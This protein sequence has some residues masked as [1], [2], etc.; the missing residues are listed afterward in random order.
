MA[1]VGHD[2]NP[3]AVQAKS[4]RSSISGNVQ[5]DEPSSRSPSKPAAHK[6]DHSTSTTHNKKSGKAR[7]TFPASRQA[8]TSSG[9]SVG[10][11]I[12]GYPKDVHSSDCSSRPG[13]AGYVRPAGLQ[14]DL[15]TDR[16]VPVGQL[17]TTVACEQY[18]LSGVSCTAS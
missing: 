9:A 2:P 14:P 4:Q 11:M 7:E 6:T 1:D 8:S 17:H 3:Q 5:P 12:P 10:E 15:P 16:S 18:I 13:Q